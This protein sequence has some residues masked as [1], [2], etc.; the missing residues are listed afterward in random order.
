MSVIPPV[1]PC[2][3]LHPGMETQPA[4]PNKVFFHHA[5]R[6]PGGLTRYVTWVADGE[7]V[8]LGRDLLYRDRQ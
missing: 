2:D 5:V 7:V 8:F 1:K 4:T 6:K 3:C